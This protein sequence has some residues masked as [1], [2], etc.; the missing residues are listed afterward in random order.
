[1]KPKNANLNYRRLRSRLIARGWN[2]KRFAEDRGIPLSTVY[3]AATGTRAGVD[4]VKILRD[5]EKL[6]NA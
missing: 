5:L 2:L 1:M 4:S 3:C 6:A